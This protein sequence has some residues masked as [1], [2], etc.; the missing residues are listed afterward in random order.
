MMDP[1]M[2][3][4]GFVGGE[5]WP[6]ARSEGRVLPLGSAALGKLEL[7]KRRALL[8]LSILFVQESGFWGLV[9]SRESSALFSSSKQ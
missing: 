7:S 3:L 9:Y 6:L 1:Q 5:Y 2:A 8:N 4:L